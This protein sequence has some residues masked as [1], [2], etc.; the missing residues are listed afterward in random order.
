[1][2][3]SVFDGI[4]RAMQAAD[5]FAERAPELAA[6]S[7]QMVREYAQKL[8]LT[9]RELQYAGVPSRYVEELRPASDNILMMKGKSHDFVKDL[10]GLDKIDDLRL[11]HGVSHSK[12]IAYSEVNLAGE[13][14]EE[15]V[16]ISG[17]KAP[18]D[19]VGMPEAPKFEPRPQGYDLRDNHSETKIL[20]RIAEKATPNSKGVVTIY[21][22]RE[23][24]PSCEDIVRQFREMFPGIV[25]RVKYGFNR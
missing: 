13:E 11:Q 14:A 17:N 7:R 10:D 1:V 2:D 3:K 9:P 12:N 24:C 4:T 25:L 15:L 20:E 22:E 23:P 6:Q 19:T 5:K 18:G 21:T 8:N 16:A